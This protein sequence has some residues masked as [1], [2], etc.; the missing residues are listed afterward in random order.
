[1]YNRRFLPVFVA[2]LLF[3]SSFAS[4]ASRPGWTSKKV[5]LRAG[6]GRRIKAI[7][8]PQGKEVQ[9]RHQKQKREKNKV[10]KKPRPVRANPLSNDSVSIQPSEVSTGSVFVNTIESPPI[11][12]FIPWIAVTATDERLDDGEINAVLENSLVGDYLPDNAEGDFVIGLFDTG[13]SAHVI[14]YESAETLGIKE[15]METGN[16]IEIRGVTGS[17]YPRVTLPLGVFIAGFDAIDPVTMT[18][19]T[20]ALVGQSNVAIAAGDYPE[21]GAPD[22]PTAIGSPMSVFYDTVFKNDQPITIHR[23]G[24]NYTSPDIRIYRNKYGNREEYGDPF[25]YEDPDEFVNPN[26]PNYPIDIPLEL[27]PGGAGMVS[28]IFSLGD[29]IFNFEYLPSSPSVII[30]NSSQS[31]F[32][33]HAVDLYENDNIAFDKDRFMIDTGAQVT[34]IGKRIAARL[35]IDPDQ[36]EFVVDIEGVSG[37]VSEIGGYYIDEIEIPALGEWVSFTNVPVILLDI[38]SP[39]GGTL[40]GII[41]MNLFNEYNMVFHGSGMSFED[42]PSLE[43]E[44]ITTPPTSLAGDIAPD[45]VDGVVDVQDMQVFMQAWL[46]SNENPGFNYIC[47]IAP[48]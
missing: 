12:G 19:D 30:G 31:L 44:L 39:E 15:N 25:I 20:S 42:D 36:P 9:M 1:M 43:L 41:G 35:G 37:E 29:D 11:N 32:F 6:D 7:H 48:E 4:A 3:F 8:Y 33:V 34:V 5:D 13:A 28:Y 46:T 45:P 21:P 14:G 18:V 17:V 26:V 22:L 2:L 47:D 16:Y 27:R 23:D 24:K 38:A 10:N 40:D